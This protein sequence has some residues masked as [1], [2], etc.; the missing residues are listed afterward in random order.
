MFIEGKRPVALKPKVRPASYL[1]QALR[2]MLGWSSLSAA[3]P[4]ISAW[5]VQLMMMFGSV[6]LSPGHILTPPTL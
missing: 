6:F 3:L 4:G 1:H 2:R 5:D